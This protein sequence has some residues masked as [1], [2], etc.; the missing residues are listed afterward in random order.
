MLDVNQLKLPNISEAG[1]QALELLSD[2]LIEMAY[3]ADFLGKDP[4]IS[5]NL[6][7]YANSPVYH[8]QVEVKSIR[9]AVSLLGL[10]RCKMAVGVTILQTYS[11]KANTITEMVWSHCTSVATVA[12]L[13]AEK[14]HPALVDDIETTALMHDMGILVMVSSFPDTYIP[15]VEQCIKERKPL[16][17]SEKNTYAFTHDQVF[18][19]LA[20]KLRLPHST[21]ESVKLFHSPEPLIGIEKEEYIHLAIC[22]LAHLLVYEYNDRNGTAC[23]AISEHLA[24]DIDN[25]TSILNISD[26]ML[27]DLIE[28]SEM[29]LNIL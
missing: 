18:E 3:L 28:D 6:L 25:L 17:E 27:G 15:L 23:H 1:Q 7:K 8:R 19:H 13:I 29:M 5:A 12:R 22:H 9:S 26:N 21:T 10:K 24:N 4:T 14:T 16:A 20:K 11:C 2:D